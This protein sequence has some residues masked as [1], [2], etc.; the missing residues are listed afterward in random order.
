MQLT[1]AIHDLNYSYSRISH[2]RKR[3]QL[4]TSSC[5]LRFYMSNSTQHPTILVPDAQ[6]KPPLGN[7]SQTKFAESESRNQH[8][9]LQG[10]TSATVQESR[11]R[12]LYQTT[13]THLPRPPFP[14]TKVHSL[15]NF[16]T[17]RSHRL[18]LSQ[19][20]SR[21]FTEIT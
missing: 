15:L 10:E 1:K 14:H 17:G 7:S 21:G 11:Y 3:L 6:D 20:L 8:R 18:L 16:L 2:K 5:L 19:S 9:E 12:Y 4:P 13:N